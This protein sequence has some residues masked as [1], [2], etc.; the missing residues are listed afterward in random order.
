MNISTFDLTLLTA[1]S[2]LKEF[3]NSYTNHKEIFDMQERHDNMELNT[4]K[5]FFSENYSMDICK[6]ISAIIFPPGNSFYNIFIM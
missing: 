5:K 6:F 2:N 1:L 3:I 4:N